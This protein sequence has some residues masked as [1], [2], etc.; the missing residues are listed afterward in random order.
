MKSDRR[1]WKRNC[2]YKKSQFLW[3]CN[4]SFYCL[5]GFHCFFSLILFQTVLILVGRAVSIDRRVGQAYNLLNHKI[6]GAVYN[7]VYIYIFYNYLFR[8]SM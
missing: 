1:D 6:F 7:K 4:D 2:F 3:F 5:C 8:E